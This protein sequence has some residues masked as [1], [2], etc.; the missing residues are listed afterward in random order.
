MKTNYHSRKQNGFSLIETLISIAILGVVSITY[1]TTRT[2]VVTSGK[3]QE[4]QQNVVALRHYI[5]TNFSCEDTME[6]NKAYAR[7]GGF[8]SAQRCPYVNPK[9]GFIVGYNIEGKA[10]LGHKN[11]VKVGDF[12]IWTTCSEEPTSQPLVRIPH[13]RF[14]AKALKSDGTPLMHPVTGAAMRDIDI[15]DGMTTRCQMPDLPAVPRPGGA[16]SVTMRDYK[17]SSNPT[18]TIIGGEFSSQRG[19]SYDYRYELRSPYDFAATN[20]GKPASWQIHFINNTWSSNNVSSKFDIGSSAVETPAAN[21]ITSMPECVVKNPTDP[22]EVA[23]VGSNPNCKYWKDDYRLA[24]FTTP[25]GW[26][27]SQ[28][29]MVVEALDSS[30]NKIS[31]CRFSMKVSEPLVFTW[32][33]VDQ[34][35]QA[36]HQTLVDFDYNGSGK[37]QKMGWVGGNDIAF[38]TL[39]LNG[40][41]MIDDGTELFGDSTKLNDGTLAKHG[42]LALAQYDSDGNGLIDKN[43]PVF[44]KLRLWFDG[45]GNGESDP[46]ELYAPDAVAVTSIGLKFKEV[47]QPPPG[48]NV[49]ARFAYEGVFYGP[50]RCEKVG[51]RTYDVYFGFQEQQS[52]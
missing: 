24:Q 26:Y 19:G 44:S 33:P 48:A 12:N 14:M 8:V 45:D 34:P 21:P 28:V 49:M 37:K 4:V 17:K 41:G 52:F 43:D 18:N 2:N 38:L 27:D 5:R 10:M 51:C 7:I 6:I 31:E 20:Q 1:L 35:P 3:Y 40:N 29:D 13:F 47:D 30:K 9:T 50:G 15:F 25:K 22:V 11:P 36:V 32:R 46:W 42:Y 39:D 23:L 16:C